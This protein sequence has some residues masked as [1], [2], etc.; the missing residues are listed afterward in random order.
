MKGAIYLDNAATTYPKPRSVIRRTLYAIEAAGGN[1]GRSGHTLSRCAEEAVYA[2]RC[3]IADF[4]HSDAPERVVFTYNATYAL[5]LAI[6]ALAQARTHILI[7]DLEHNAVLRPV[8][9]L[10]REGLCDY[11][12]VH[13]YASPDKSARD[14]ALLCDMEKKLRPTTR[15]VVMTHASNLCSVSLPL[16]EIGAFC[17]RHNLYLVVDA[18]QSAGHLDIDIE[19]M[20]IDALCFPAHKGLYG[21]TGCGGVL[22]SRRLAE[23]TA[24]LSPL[25]F[26][27]SGVYSKE[28]TMPDFLPEH[29]EAGT[30]SVPAIAALG[31]GVAFVKGRKEEIASRE[32]ALFQKAAEGLSQLPSFRVIAPNDRGAVLLFDSARFSPSVIGAHL[33]ECGICVRA[34]LHCAP[35]AHKTL[36]C[37]EDGAVRV[38][39]GA[40]NS[41]SDI[42]LFLCAMQD[43]ARKA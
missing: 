12:I 26:G 17:R 10:K 16:A 25:L 19:K 35:L 39:F 11:D 14:A 31:A 43:L 28:E 13:A 38:S 2:T 24:S 15:M 21:I 29:F 27:G 37:G 7:S 23:R 36:S 42:D 9:A 22:F 6:R 32:S 34:G 4:F 1:P 5:N 33:D 3:A 30:L 18:S 8:A 20:H 41:P 40:F